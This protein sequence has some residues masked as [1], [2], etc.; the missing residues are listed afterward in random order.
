M[1]CAVTTLDFLPVEYVR[2]RETRRRHAQ[3]RLIVCAAA[4]LIVCGI[5]GQ[6]REQAVLSARVERMQRDLVTLEAQI[7][8]TAA[9]Q[10]ELAALD[11][12]LRWWKLLRW[13]QSP[14]DMLA[15]FSSTVPQEVVLTALVLAGEARPIAATGGLSMSPTSPVPLPAARRDLDSLLRRRQAESV[16]VTIEGMATDDIAITHWL[17]AL[18]QDRRF[19]RVDLISLDQLQH[20]AETSRSFSIRLQLANPFAGKPDPSPAATG[21]PLIPPREGPR[22]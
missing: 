19:E 13:R 12:E 1:E 5:V 20:D 3:Y 9:L 4:G 8:D 21:A 15:T 7:A 16:I 17:T 2:L 11:E 22:A 10:T 14:A 6:L 18:H